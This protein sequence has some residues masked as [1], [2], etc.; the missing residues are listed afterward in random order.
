MDDTIRDCI[1]GR[2]NIQG[3]S[4]SWEVTVLVI[5]RKQIHIKMSL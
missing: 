1:P 5:V 4:V 3:Q 2:S